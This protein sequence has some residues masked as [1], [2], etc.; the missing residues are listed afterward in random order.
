[1]NTFGTTRD[2][3]EEHPVNAFASILDSWDPASNA[4]IE[5]EVQSEKTARERISTEEGIV[6][7]GIDEQLEKAPIPIVF[8][9]DIEANVTSERKM[10][11]AKQHVASRQ[12]A[13]Q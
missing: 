8:K 11:F 1:M 5:S 10:Q 3:R 13:K 12:F 9:L 4:N 2:F 7:D 6:I